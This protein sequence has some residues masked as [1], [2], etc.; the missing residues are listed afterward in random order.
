VAH[1]F[2]DRH[3][4]EVTT[5]GEEQHHRR[6]ML[7]PSILSDFQPAYPWQ[8]EVEQEQIERALYQQIERLFAVGRHC[9]GVSNTP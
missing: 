7:F 9:N 1:L 4:V 8:F 5:A 6:R 2:L 3:T